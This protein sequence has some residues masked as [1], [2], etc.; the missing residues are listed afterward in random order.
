MVGLDIVIVNWNTGEYLDSCLSSI[1]R[2]GIE[3][4]AKVVV[5]DNASSDE[6]L[7]ALDHFD[8]PFHLVRNESNHGFA[9][10]CNQGAELCHSDYLLF[11]NPDT[12]LFDGALAEPLTFMD[13]P[14]NSRVGICGV[15]MIDEGGLVARS[16][17]K[18]PT[19]LR[20]M[21]DA[22]G[23]SKVPGLRW[24]GVHMNAWDHSSS[25]NV[26]HVMGAFFLVRK[27]VF[28]SLKGFDED[29]FVYLEDVDFSFRARDC[30]WAT[31]YLS[32]GRIFHAGGGASGRVKDVRLFY[33]IR[34]RLIYG[35][36]HFSLWQAWLLL[37]LTVFLEPLLR[38]AFSFARGGVR[39]VSDTCRGFGMVYR[40]LPSIVLGTRKR[41]AS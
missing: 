32:T 16:C 9:C 27:S 8:L 2:F 12:E 22:T 17:A 11:L 15:Q 41:V 25:R 35:F 23:V 26:D 24:T 21:A 33:A 29:F 14:A 19:L 36:K 10:A 38:I 4:V 20:F 13:K 6:S 1:E 34:S 40:S 39:E 31:E 7:R 30:G 3:Q 37:A 28:R 18:F 5:V